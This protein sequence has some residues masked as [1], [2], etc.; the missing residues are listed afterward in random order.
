M[1]VASRMPGYPAMLAVIF[2]LGGG[3]KTVAVL[4]GLMGG[5]TVLMTFWMGSRLCRATGMVAAALLA[6]DPLTVGF[7][8]A[9][10]TETPFTLCMMAGLML[11]VR[12][13]EAEKVA[14]KRWAGMGL[15]VGLGVLWGV[16]VY[17]RAEALWLIVPLAGWAAWQLRGR[18]IA[19]MGLACV[20][21]GIVFLMLMP[22]W[23]RNCNRFGSGFFRMTTL[24]GISLYEAVYPEADGG[25]QQHK[26]DP[27]PA[28][29]KGMNE[30]QRNDEWARRAWG[31]VRAEP[32]RV[33]KLAVVKM[34]RTWSPW[35]NAAEMRNGALQVAMAAW[36]V[37]VFLLAVLGL[38]RMPGRMLVL[39]FLPVAYFTAVH[40]VYLGSVR[41]RVAVMPVVFL[42][43]ARGILGIKGWRKLPKRI[44]SE[45]V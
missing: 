38:M 44:G 10:L 19:R 20:P 35:F 26:I 21:V 12:I 15:W 18:V 31:Y 22:W 9:V 37:P 11:C 7:S 5:L 30:A 28:E 14:E 17:L 36:Y 27:L 25:P 1:L 13:A 39:W 24:E 23:V 6:I 4:Q 8:A 41:Y 16:A 32:L 40:A 45:G 33:G 42:L 3:I 2:W 43:A 29:M 34:G